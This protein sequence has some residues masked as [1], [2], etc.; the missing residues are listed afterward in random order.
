MNNIKV[1]LQKKKVQYMGVENM[2]SDVSSL[3]R[4]GHVYSFLK[5]IQMSVSLAENKMS[6]N[7]IIRH[8]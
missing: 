2:Y 8:T 4:R 6:K 1:Y 5:K 3:A 7:I